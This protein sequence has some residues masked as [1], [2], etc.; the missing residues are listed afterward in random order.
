MRAL[1][2]RTL[3][4]EQLATLVQPIHIAST[5]PFSISLLPYR[6]HLVQAAIT[7]AK[8]HDS[9]SAQEA[10]GILLAKY[11]TQ[12]VHVDN[13]V[14]VPVPLS[15]TR[16]RE[17]G[18]NQVERICKA[19]L[20]QLSLNKPKGTLDAGLLIRSRDTPPQTTLGAAAR[21]LN[22]QGA[23]Q[24]LRPINLHTLYIVVDDVITTGATL[25]SVTSTLQKAG[26][27][28]IL[29]IALAHSP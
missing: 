9:H 26:A 15:R 23:F 8:F 21:R 4:Y 17:R 19:A 27:V 14:L 7:E 11:L 10:L 16:L 18:Y 2:A 5:E 12:T 20:K 25:L 24:V 3:S 29:P 13:F 1:R 28:S 6:N 22:L